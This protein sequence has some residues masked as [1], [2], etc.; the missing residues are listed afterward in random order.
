MSEII[1]LLIC[2]EPYLSS[3][4]LRQLRHLVFAML[5]IPKQVTMLGLSRWTEKG[6]SYRTLQRFYQNKIDWAQLHWQIIKAHLLASEG[7][8][9][10][11]GDDVVVSKSGKQTHGVGR[12]YSGL[13]QR[14][15]PSMSFLA[16]SL[17][18]VKARRSYPLQIGQN[19]PK[20]RSKQQVS[21]KPKRKRGRPKGSKNHVKADPILTPELSL[22]VHILSEI[23]T[24][25]GLLKL[26][27]IVLDGKFG[28]YPST[29]AVRQTGLHIISKMRQDAALYFPYKGSK[30]ARGSTSRYGEKINYSNLPAEALSESRIEGDYCIEIY[31]MRLFHKDYP[32]ALNVV[33]IVKTHLKTGKRGHVVLFSTDLD[34]SA[35]QIVDYYSLRFQIEFNFR[36]AKQYWGLEDFMNITPTAVSNAVNLSFLMVNLSIALLKPYRQDNSDFSIRD[37]KSQFQARRYLDE[38]IKMLPNPPNEHLIS[39]IWHKLT[40]F[41]SIRTRQIEPPAA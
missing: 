24:R 5:C 20:S 28:N 41:G 22:L 11:A 13:A 17:I 23:L 38:T 16:I 1:P 26:K 35:A 40:R 31:Q 19:Q 36:D 3:T 32:D 15:I 21:D 34:L 30:P 7:L 9:F 25:L 18:D 27:H 10:L 2:L 4:R 39:R 8:Y 12:F 14:V 33:V 29:W 6:G 37:L